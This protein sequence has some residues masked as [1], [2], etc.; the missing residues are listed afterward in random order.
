MT[1]N[2]IY[3]ALLLAISSSVFAD[4]GV[5]PVVQAIRQSGGGAGR[6]EVCHALK[7]ANATVTTVAEQKIKS[8]A[9]RF[10]AQK[11]K[12]SDASMLRAR[13]DAARKGLYG[14]RQD[15]ALALMLYE[16]AKS[17]EAGLNAALMR[18]QAADIT[19]NPAVAKQIL[20]TLY[21]SGA[22]KERS[23]GLV[24]SQAHYLAGLIQ[25]GGYA[26][27]RDTKKAF[28]HYRASA[29]ATYVPGIYHYLRLNIESLPKLTD[30]ERQS[31]IPEVRLM[32]NRWR[33]QSADIMMLNGD[34]YAAGWFP[35][36]ADGFFAQY[37]WRIA[38]N[39]GG[40]KEIKDF[41]SLIQKRI[42]RLSKEKE[43]RLE[44]AVK[45]A[46]SNVSNVPHNL[47]FMDLCAE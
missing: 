39:M 21:K 38:Q 2:K 20:D 17:Q 46:M 12:N 34:L 8:D 47:E 3:P 41:D 44:G 27:E 33:W 45:A 19:V 43:E 40:R 15:S 35:D 26:G 32:S 6:L 16:K 24:G 30:A 10:V 9:V 1:A 13:A 25:E 7:K 18:Y 42:K 14:Y 36:E 29:R 22:A 5:D 37:Y 11:L 28:L 31:V 23:R 4:Q